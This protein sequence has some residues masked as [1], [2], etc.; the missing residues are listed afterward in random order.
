[1]R[2]QA[3]LALLALSCGDKDETA[4]VVTSDDTAT[5]APVDAD[6]D[7]WEAPDDC[8][9]LDAA[10]HPD[11]TEI[12]D[13]KDDDC[14]GTV[15]N[16]DAGDADTWYA[17]ADG[18]GFGDP[19]VS[20]EACTPPSAYV[21]D[22]SDCDDA[23]P[24]V[25]PGA[26]EYCDGVDTDCNGILDDG[27]ALDAGT[28]YADAD[29]DGRGDASAPIVACSPPA[30]AVA[31]ADDCDD[32]EPKAWTGAVEDCDDGIDQ[33][34]DAL[35]DC[36]DGD[37][38]MADCGEIDCEDGLDNDADGALDCV[39]DDCWGLTACAF[40]HQLVTLPSGSGYALGGSGLS[41]GPG[42][43]TAWS[44]A[45]HDRQGLLRARPNASAAWQT[46][47]WSFPIG[48]AQFNGIPGRPMEITLR[49]SF[50]ISGSCGTSGSAFLPTTFSASGTFGVDWW[51]PAWM[52]SKGSTVVG[53]D[54]WYSGL[55]VGKG[56]RTT[57]YHRPWRSYS[58][59]RTMTVNWP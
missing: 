39:D 43:Y 26:D 1:M 22:A 6:G 58:F 29:K 57:T 53:L 48:G 18:D 17:D 37:C 14:D 25:A 7:G 31:N 20:L 12:C 28:W 38:A 33:D 56:V 30:G 24:Q 10:V 23:D 11:A 59:P 47:A 2:P 55:R 40:Q 50:Q 21:A 54:Q 27:Y 44:L 16:P 15:D 49:R 34:C 36:E 42:I 41:S 35:I 51:G 45:L 4:P 13:G 52:T 19:L 9:D 46:C 3:L 8:D 5:T 32:G